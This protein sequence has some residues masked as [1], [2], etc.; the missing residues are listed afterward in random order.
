MSNHMQLKYSFINRS[1]GAQQMC[2][3]LAG[4]KC[5]IWEDV[6]QRIVDAIPSYIDVCIM[7]SGLYDSKLDD[8]SKKNKW[9][10]LYTKK[11]QISAIQNLA[12]ELHPNAKWI[13]KIDEDIFLT[14]GFFERLMESWL[15][16]EKSTDACPSIVAP[17]I[18]VNG[19]TYS[20]ILDKCELR[21]K[22]EQK[23]GNV[24]YSSGIEHHKWTREDGDFARY[25]WGS[26]EDK[27]ADIDELTRQFNQGPLAISFCPVRF[28]I[29]AILFNRDFFEEMGGFPVDS[30]N[31]LGI[32]EER[33]CWFAMNNARP[34]VV[35][36][37][38]V[39]G[40]LGFGPQTTA[41]MQYYGQNPNIF[42]SKG[43][44]K[45][46]QEIRIAVSCHKNSIIPESTIYLPI[47]VGASKRSVHLADCQRDDIGENISNLNYSFSELTAQYWMWKNLDL[48]FYGQCHYRRYFYLGSKQ[49]EM[50]DHAQIEE[51]VLDSV[52]SSKFVLDNKSL[53]VE[54]IENYD[55][56][57]PLSWDVS[58]A[59]TPQGYKMSVREHMIAYD[60]ISDRDIEQLIEITDKLVPEWATGVRRYLEGRE[61]IGY[62][63]FLMKRELFNKFCEKEFAILLRFAGRDSF[64]GLEE[65]LCGYLGEILFSV[66]IKECENNRVRVKRAP[67]VFFRR[68]SS[69]KNIPIQNRPNSGVKRL[70][71]PSR[72]FINRRFN[73][74]LDAINGIK[75]CGT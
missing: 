71:P 54:A 4:Y 20:K 35:N 59:P 70:I 57:A 45:D 63:C 50:N 37:N 73:E 72:N 29:G 23:Y 18:N 22:Y 43:I 11:N 14:R 12:I 49:Y 74:V 56:V 16:V 13:Y 2:M 65:R 25:M 61:Y 46:K 7:S 17:L 67:L 31:G 34:I 44:V 42:K 8:I 58:K 48:E 26:D 33:I 27:L 53:I 51:E 36:E 28:S 24:K 32:D 52:S 5:A 38:I 21:E 62:N 39:V 41:M 1:N 30:G 55:I 47:E 10:Y 66:F 60:L 9:S 3:I 40:H 6:F 19:Y 15:Y 69:V 68:T 64:E 75:S